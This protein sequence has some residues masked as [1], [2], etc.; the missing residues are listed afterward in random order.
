MRGKHVT[1]SWS[2][3]GFVGIICAVCTPRAPSAAH[4]CAECALRAPL[5]A[6]IPTKRELLINCVL[7]ARLG[8]NTCPQH[9]WFDPA[10][11]LHLARS[12]LGSG[13]RPK[14]VPWPYKA[15][16]PGSLSGNLCTRVRKSLSRH[17]W[18][19]RKE[20]Q[21]CSSHRTPPRTTASQQDH[22]VAGGETVRQGM[23]KLI[24]SL[25]N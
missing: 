1:Y 21:D 22:M 3:S 6:R 5:A 24:W 12:L 14:H 2:V 9:I 7:H 10:R 19:E 11:Y 17:C 25:F 8:S 20:P 16:P 15:S 13:L 4:I 18:I 23:Q